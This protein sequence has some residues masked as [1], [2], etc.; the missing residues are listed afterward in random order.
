MLNRIQ[1]RPITV[2]QVADSSDERHGKACCTPAALM[3]LV[4][5]CRKRRPPGHQDKETL[6]NL[7]VG[8]LSLGEGSTCAL[9]SV[10]HRVV[11]PK[12]ELS[13]VYEVDLVVTVLSDGRPEARY[14]LVRRSQTS[15]GA[16]PLSLRDGCFDKSV[17]PWFC[18]LS[19][20]YRKARRNR[21]ALNKTTFGSRVR[22]SKPDYG[23]GCVAHAGFDR[24]R[25]G[26]ASISFEGM[27][28]EGESGKPSLLVKR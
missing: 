13:S 24:Q 6:N 12:Y 15:D 25:Y 5:V 9:I 28:K 4:A 17:N 16:S 27:P 26:M 20:S 7:R 10:R 18:L 21:R 22:T 23:S 2:I 8:L 19:T 1:R 14:T 3:G 11:G